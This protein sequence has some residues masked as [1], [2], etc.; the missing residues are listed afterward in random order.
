MTKTFQFQAALFVAAM[1]A[2]PLVQSQTLTKADF[3]AGKTRISADYKTEKASCA[4]FSGNGRDVCIEEAKAHEKVARAELQF[5]Y[6]AKASDENKLHVVRAETAYD[7]AKEKCDDLAGNDKH[8]CVKEAKAIEVRS[9]TDARVTKQVGD[10]RSDAA[11]DVRNADY[12]VATEK[13]DALSGDAKTS[14]MA[15]AKA[16]FHKI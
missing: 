3:E 14:C 15:S 2:L 4:S 6:T 7:V 13:C 5:G 10:A 8:V 16:K 1:L 12:K 11:A 9:L